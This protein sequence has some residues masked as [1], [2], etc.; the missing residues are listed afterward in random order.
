MY[1]VGIRLLPWR[2]LPGQVCLCA[3]IRRGAGY[4]CSIKTRTSLV[5]AL[6]EGISNIQVV[7][8]FLRWGKK[9]DKN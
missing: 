1:I 4:L 7:L 9:E 5:G 8:R 6:Y 3:L 2:I